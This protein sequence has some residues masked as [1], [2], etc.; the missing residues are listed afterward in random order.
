MLGN[1]MTKS[2]FF[3]RYSGRL[4][5]VFLLNVVYVLLTV[6]VFV[7]I[8]PFVKLLFRGTLEGLSPVSAFVMQRVGS[9]LPLDTLSRSMVVVI[10]FAALLFFTA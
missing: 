4:A 7:M 2:S 8:E 5:V 9:V 10:V 1:S 3:K 6:F